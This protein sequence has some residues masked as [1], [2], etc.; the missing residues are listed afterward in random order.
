MSNERSSDQLHPGL[1]IKIIGALLATLMGVVGFVVNKAANS[2]QDLTKEVGALREQLAE[3]VAEKKGEVARVDRIE[4]DVTGVKND[5][6]DLYTLHQ[7]SLETFHGAKVPKA[8]HR[9]N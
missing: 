2:M 9:K 4:K 7:W 5:V 1:L 6:N 8:F 3:V